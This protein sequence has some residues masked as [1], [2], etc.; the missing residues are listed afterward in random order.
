MRF[1]YSLLVYLAT[2]VLLLYLGFRGLRDRGYLRRWP[3]RF[4]LYGGA[5]GGETL[6]FHC[7]SVGEVNAAGPL[8][9]AL[10][11]ARPSQRLLVTTFTPTGSRRVRDLFGD[12]VDH[13]FAPLDLPG[14]VRRFYRRQ[15]PRLLVVVET[16]IW[17]N[18]YAAATARD[19][20][21]LLVNAR[22][23]PSSVR[24]YSRWRGLFGAALNQARCILTQGQLDHDRFIACGAEPD[25]V[26]ITGNLKFDVDIHPRHREA[27]ELLQAAWG[28]NRPVLTAG[29]THEDDE[30]I[31]FRAFRQSLER[32][33]SALLVIAPRHPERFTRAAQAAR[34]AGFEVQLLSQGGRIAPHTNC[35]VVD[36]MGELL[37]YYA[38]ADVTFLGGTLAEIG[39]HNILEPAALGKPVLTGPHTENIEEIADMLI[40][41]GAARSVRNDSELS[42]LLDGLFADGAQRDRMGQAGQALVRANRGALQKTLR[43]IEKALPESR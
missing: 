14:A 35:L 5:D 20:P 13:V 11:A 16:E 25:R 27:G 30:T 37:N 15:A 39:G 3:E 29:S 43:E 18:L 10:L 17:P 36:T 9:R 21:L 33:P 26:R 38:A 12:A 19:I 41:A 40:E 23:S 42:L 6:V 32:H 7:A 31:L 22:L 24:N 4:A 28:V 2:P 1:F 8:V 34:D